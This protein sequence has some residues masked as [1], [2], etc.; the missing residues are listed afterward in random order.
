M[1]MYNKDGKVVDV[2]KHQMA[3][4][5]EHGW[6]RGTGPG[7]S[8]KVEDVEEVVVEEKVEAVADTAD[9]D[10]SDA[11]DADD[12]DADGPAPKKRKKI[13]RSSK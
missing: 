13:K 1:K 4:F 3:L 7:T 2:E 9:A 10:D 6:V 11:S 5:E 12:S 8:A